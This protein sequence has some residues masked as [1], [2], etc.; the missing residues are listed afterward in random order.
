LRSGLSSLIVRLYNEGHG[1]IAGCLVQKSNDPTIAAA[2][3][4]AEGEGDLD[5]VD[6]EGSEGS[7]PPTSTPAEA[8]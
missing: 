8:V 5:Q 2:Y 6:E 3:A 1:N 7:G 4:A